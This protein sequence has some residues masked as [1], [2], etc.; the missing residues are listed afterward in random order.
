MSE[1]KTVLITGASSGIGQEIAQR[2]AQAGHTVFGTSRNPADQKQPSNFKLLPL[3]V[4]SDAS[5]KSCVESV[6]EQAGRLDVLINNAGYIVLGAIEESSMEQAKDIFETNF[7]GAIRMCHLALPIMRKQGQGQIINITSLAGLN[8]VPYWGLYN[9][10]K[11]ALEGLTESLRHE[12]KPLNISVALVEPSFFKSS[13]QR[14]WA[15]I[16]ELHESRPE[17][18]LVAETVLKIVESKAPKLR[19]LLGKDVIY[20][21]LRQL[22]PSAMFESAARDY[23]NLD[24]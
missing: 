14:A 6:M 2:L 5:A 1:K 21:W 8:P 15:R 7:F 17:P 22:M 4:R 23:W 18:R 12:L 3:D 10:S 16:R 11:F 19:H 20:Y 9:A 13:R 24:G